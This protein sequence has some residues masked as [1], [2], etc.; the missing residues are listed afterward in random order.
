MV[1]IFGM[2]VVE[3]PLNSPSIAASSRTKLCKFFIRARLALLQSPDLMD[4]PPAKQNR[5]HRTVT[6]KA[7]G[8]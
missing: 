3:G 5:R 8:R 2:D 1:V 4:S 6:D 7:Y